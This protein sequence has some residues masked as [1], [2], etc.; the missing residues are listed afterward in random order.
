ME[1]LK[2]KTFIFQKREIFGRFI[3]AAAMAFGFAACGDDGGGGAVPIP[4]GYGITGSC[5]DIGC[6]Q[7][8]N[9]P[10]Q[11]AQFTASNVRQAVQLNVALHG[12]RNILM[13]QS[14]PMNTP[15]AS[16]H[17][18]VTATGQ[19]IATTPLV[20]MSGRCQIPPGSYQ[21]TTNNIAGMLGS[22]VGGNLE[23]PDL[24][25]IPGNIRIQITQGIMYNGGTKLMGI[26]RILS[27]NGMQCDPYFTDNLY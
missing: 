18:P 26:L 11:L 19:F 13:S 21:I 1:R 15:Y 24:L 23:L 6:Q 5:S 10:M 20:D 16:Y 17:G 2:W 12:S 25:L 9:S 3:V 8:S 14:T 7:V 22:P 27:A 4:I